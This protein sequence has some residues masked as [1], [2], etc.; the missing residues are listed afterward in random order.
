MENITIRHT[1]VI[2]LLK[3]LNPKKA[4]GPDLVPTTILKQYADIYRTHP[5]TDFSAEP[6]YK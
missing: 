1:G 3:F 5:T 6:R 4:I 2:K